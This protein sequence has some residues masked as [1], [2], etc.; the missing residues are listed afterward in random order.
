[1]KDKFQK[2]LDSSDL[3]KADEILGQIMTIFLADLSLQISN[4]KQKDFN[5]GKKLCTINSN[6]SNALAKTEQKAET[7]KTPESEIEKPVQKNQI[8]NNARFKLGEFEISEARDSNEI[9]KALKKL[10]VKKIDSLLEGSSE[11]N[12]QQ[13]KK[14]F[15]SFRGTVIDSVGKIYGTMVFEI[16]STPS[17][18]RPI[19][20][21]IKLYQNG[22]ERVGD[23]F[24]TD[25]L[26]SA[27]SSST[28]TVI[29]FGSSKYLQVYKIESEQKIAGYYYEVLP[30]RTSKTIGTFVLSRTDFVD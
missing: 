9:F 15:G 3:K 11:A 17:G 12:Y 30:N 21:S 28:A 26:G 22:I 6:T 24:S 8:Q 14:F 4:E 7:V 18:K 2:L 27:L 20:G 25:G 1:M 16:K 13:S 10:E 5:D 29:E 23:D 19:S